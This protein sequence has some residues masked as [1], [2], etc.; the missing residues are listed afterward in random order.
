MEKTQTKHLLFRVDLNKIVGDRSL[1]G[2]EEKSVKLES[3]HMCMLLEA[4]LRFCLSGPQMAIPKKGVV[5]A[6]A[7]AFGRFTLHRHSCDPP[8]LGRAYR[9]GF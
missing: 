3:L 5:W 1:I 7:C 2:F 6:A 8:I 4:N 9:R